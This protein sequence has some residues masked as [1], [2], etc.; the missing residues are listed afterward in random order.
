MLST[1]QHLSTLSIKLLFWEDRPFDGGR[2]DSAWKDNG[3]LSWL[4]N[5]PHPLKSLTY[6]HDWIRLIENDSE[7]K[8]NENKDQLSVLKQKYSFMDHLQEL[9][10]IN[11]RLIHKA[12]TNLSFMFKKGVYYN[13]L[14]TLNIIFTNEH[15]IEEILINFYSWL[16]LFPNLKKLMIEENNNMVYKGMDKRNLRIELQRQVQQQNKIYPL[17]E[18]NIIGAELLL[19]NGLTGIGHACPSLKKLRLIDVLVSDGYDTIND[20]ADVI[21]MDTPHLKLDEFV[22]A[23]MY[24]AANKDIPKNIKRSF[25]LITT[26][27][28]KRND[29]RDQHFTIKL[30]SLCEKGHVPY[31]CRIKRRTYDI[32]DNKDK[33]YPSIQVI[34]NCE[35]VDFI[36]C[37]N[38]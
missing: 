10:L 38:Y 13:Q 20:N 28:F 8:N 37:I 18:L 2:E 27:S 7:I 3:F 5:K 34:L 11:E 17:E 25:E 32:Y 26:E 36:Y 14:T 21:I 1:F 23:N 35:H 31:W 24:T 9:K 16:D 6:H 33:E 15:P 19:V 4:S 30:P 12:F 22:I 29:N